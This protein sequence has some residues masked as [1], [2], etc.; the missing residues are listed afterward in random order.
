[1]EPFIPYTHQSINEDDIQAVAQALKGNFITRGPT[2]NAFEDAIA[3]YCGAAYSVVFNSGSSALIAG[4]QAVE[5]NRFDHVFSTPN[6]FISSISGALHHDSLLRFID[7]NPQTGNI[8]LDQLKAQMDTKSSRGRNIIIPVHYS[9]L[10]VKMEIIDQ[11]IKQV[12]TVVIEDASQALGASYTNG[13]KVGSCCYSDMTI[14]S[15]HPA[16]SIATG[17]GGLVTTNNPHLYNRLLRI[18]N[19]GIIRDIN[20]Q[21]HQPWSYS[22]H[23]VSCNYHFTDFQAA[24]GLEQ[25]KRLDQFIQ[26]RKE[27]VKLYRRK[28]S[29]MRDVSLTPHNHDRLSA[30]NLFVIRINFSSYS[31]TRGIVMNKLKEFGIGTQVHFIPLYHHPYF[32]QKKNI[33]KD[34]FPNMETFYSEALS[35]PLYFDLTEK[36]VDKV[37]ES[38]KKALMFKETAPKKT[39]IIQ[40]KKLQPKRK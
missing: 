7:I 27:L 25:L 32:I 13:K 29:R 36:D 3:K 9:G 17:E 33:D 18:R 28:L 26:K 39:K 19:N 10:P 24:L 4:C 11:N 34:L 23:E 22:V 35:L 38:L 8:D 31:T 37:C 15:F 20:D 6:T 16:K 2:V 14:F 12:D 5:M 40:K 30:H 21:D 1:M